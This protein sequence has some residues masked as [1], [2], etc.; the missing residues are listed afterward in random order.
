MIRRLLALL[1]IAVLLLLAFY[2]PLLTEY[3]E[4]EPSGTPLSPPSP[5]HPLGTD[6]LGRDLFTRLLFGV[7]ISL[8]MALAAGGISI[9]IGGLLGMVSALAPVLL[10]D[11]LTWLGD[12]LLSIPGL[13]LAMLLVA[14]LGTGIT[15]V[16]LAAGIGA[17][18]GFMRVSR[19]LFMQLGEEE[20]VEAARAIGAAPI[21]IAVRH[22][23]PN[24]IPRVTV[25]SVTQMAW[26][27]VNTTT[28]SFLG[29]AGDP[30]VAEWGAMLNQGRG[31]MMD[32]PRLVLLP[33]FAITFTILALH[34]LGA[35]SVQRRFDE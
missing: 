26:A 16:I 21:R 35:S 1:W 34:T 6:H 23:L 9:A 28:L 24:A 8:S 31:F 33:G 5:Q 15:T 20:Y 17:V 30:S 10:D 32:A 19:T 7:R 11:V 4:T 25:L 29:F 12:V 2:A 22:L 18:P 27:F 13:L 14:G 3:S